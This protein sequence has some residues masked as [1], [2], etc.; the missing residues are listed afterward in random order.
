MSI[1]NLMIVAHPDDET[2]FG[3]SQLTS[4]Q[5]WKF[6]CVTNGDN[7][8]RNKEF[9]R[10]MKKL[11]TEFEIWDYEDKWGGRFNEI[12]LKNDLSRVLAE[13]QYSKVLT[14][15]SKGE[16]GHTQHISLSAIVHEL[17]KENLYVFKL[18]KK[19]LNK[20]LLEEKKKLL[21]LYKSQNLDWLKR[22]IQYEG[23]RKV[24]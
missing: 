2:I 8:I 23:I 21:R 7:R 9:K 4:G 15:N 3:F 24:Y 11:G 10:V 17:V 6:I 16:Y 12:K 22:Y 13:H 18:S 20:N 19:K 1:R 5:N 14:H